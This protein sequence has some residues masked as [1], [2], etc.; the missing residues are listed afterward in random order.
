M[1]RKQVEN[2]GAPSWSQAGQSWSQVAKWVQFSLA[3]VEAL[4]W[5]SW[6]QVE[7][8]LQPCRC[9]SRA[10]CPFWRPDPGENGTPLTEAHQS[11]RSHPLLNY[12]ASHLWCGLIYRPLSNV[13][14]DPSP[15]SGYCFLF[16]ILKTT[17]QIWRFTLWWW[18]FQ[19]LDGPSR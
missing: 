9:A 5:P 6:P 8:M 14:Q 11:A 16:V 2:K 13:I 7:M 18:S 17:V 1:A 3:E 15:Q 19:I 12:P 10:P 4:L